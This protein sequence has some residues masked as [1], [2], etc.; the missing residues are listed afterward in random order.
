MNIIVSYLFILVG[1][2]IFSTGMY[3]ISNAS[4]KC[5]SNNGVL[6]PENAQSFKIGGG[7]GATFGLIFMILGIVFTFTSSRS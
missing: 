7:F 5:I 3:Y 1:F 6:E 2:I 4:A